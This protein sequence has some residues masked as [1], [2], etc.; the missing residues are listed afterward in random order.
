MKI[1]IL[2]NYI[3]QEEHQKLSNTV[4]KIAQ[5]EEK[6]LHKTPSKQNVKNFNIVTKKAYHIKVLSV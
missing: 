2:K 3:P 4:Y 5:K 6:K 1:E